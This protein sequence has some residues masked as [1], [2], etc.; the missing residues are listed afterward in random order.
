MVTYQYGLTTLET[1]EE[2]I[3]VPAFHVA[4]FEVFTKLFGHPVLHIGK[5]GE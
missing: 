1:R 2:S 5:C 3:I 4:V